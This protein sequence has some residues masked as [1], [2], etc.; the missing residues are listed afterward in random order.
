[1]IARMLRVAPLLLLIACGR[2]GFGS[3][4]LASDGTPPDITVPTGDSAQPLVQS[5]KTS[6]SNALL[7]EGFESDTEWDYKVQ[8]F[9]TAVRSS[10]GGAQGGASLRVQIDTVDEYKAA[11]WGKNGVLSSLSSGELHLREYVWL[12]GDVTDQLSIMVTGNLLP[13]YPSANVLLVPGQVHAVVEGSSIPADFEF[14]HDR[15]VCVELHLGIDGSAGSISVDVDGSKVV[16][17]TGIDT[18]V[19]N[20]YTNIDAGFHYAT[21]SQTAATM[22]VDEVVAD[23]TPIGCD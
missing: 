6:H 18:A 11:R 16:G 5:C 14:P 15:W 10:D 19:D 21:P 3:G 13:P 8:D 1:M 22:F 12:S 17:A 4:E 7:C 9:G 20:G 2:I 23:T